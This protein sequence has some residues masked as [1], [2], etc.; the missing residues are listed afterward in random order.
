MRSPVA[1]WFFGLLLLGLGCFAI[2]SFPAFP[3]RLALA[4]LTVFLVDALGGRWFGYASVPFIAVGLLNDP[5]GTWVL[6]LPLLIGSFWGGLF[7]RHVEPGWFGVPLGML[8]FAAPLVG[9]LVLR[10]RIDPTLELPLKN[11]FS[12]YYLISGGVAILLASILIQFLRR[13]KAKPARRVP[14]R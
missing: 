4:C 7:L 5:S 12:M 8:G 10:G 3:V 13:T 1:A 9:L 6:L 14:V 2:Y 11:Q